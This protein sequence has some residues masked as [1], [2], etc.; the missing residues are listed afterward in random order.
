[1]DFLGNL[2]QCVTMRHLAAAL[3]FTTAATLLANCNSAETA[4]S[5]PTQHAEATTTVTVAS[6]TSQAITLDSIPTVNAAA[7]QGCLDEA[8]A[9]HAHVTD[10]Y[11]GGTGS[12]L[13]LNGEQSTSTELDAF[14]SAATDALTA[15]APGFVLTNHWENRRTVN[16]C[17][18]HRYAT[19]ASGDDKI[20]VSAW[21]VESAADPFWVPNEAAFEAIDDSTLVSRGGHIATVLAVAPDGTTSRVS[22]YGAR[23]QDLVSG[24]PSTAAPNPSTE[25]PGHTPITADELVPFAHELLA[26]VLSQRSQ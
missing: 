17:V 5:A 23:A 26:E 24:W 3:A 16:G 19:Y 8:G 20:V 22:V 12:P 15:V 21:R 9:L 6:Q 4:P 1:M 7:D 13:A 18:T 25:L 2:K 10:W 11:P 14:V